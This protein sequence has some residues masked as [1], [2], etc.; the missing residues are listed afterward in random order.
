MYG[1]RRELIAAFGSLFGRL[2]VKRPSSSPFRVELEERG[3]SVEV[4]CSFACSTPQEHDK[5]T[6]GYEG[7]LTD[8]ILFDHSALL[9]RRHSKEEIRY[10]VTVAK[11]S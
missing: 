11:A 9:E 1:D 7:F 3:D 8:Q 2:Q 10:V 4:I 6:V 5:S